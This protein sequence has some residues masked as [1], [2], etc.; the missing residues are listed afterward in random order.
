MN[1][2]PKPQ[3]IEILEGFFEPILIEKVHFEYFFD[4]RIFK[5]LKKINIC[6]KKVEETDAPLCLKH[7]PTLKEQQYQILILV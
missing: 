5:E 2:I 6:I 1:I 7:D 4:D 3:K